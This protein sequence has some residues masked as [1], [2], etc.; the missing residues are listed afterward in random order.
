MKQLWV[1]RDKNKDLY[2]FWTKPKK[3]IDFEQWRNQYGDSI[4]ELGKSL[5]PEVKW[6]DK[7]PTKVKLEVIK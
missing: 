5:L 7:Q 3:D 6:T 4:Q 1:A 2:L